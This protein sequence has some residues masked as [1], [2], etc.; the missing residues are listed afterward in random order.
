MQTYLDGLKNKAMFSNRRAQMLYSIHREGIHT[1]L[2]F[3]SHNH[4]HR[5]CFGM[6]TDWPDCIRSQQHWNLILWICYKVHIWIWDVTIFTFSNFSVC[7]NNRRRGFYDAF[8][9]VLTFKWK[10]LRS[11][12]RYCNCIWLCYL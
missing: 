9:F 4:S 12:H 8:V 2:V 6:F 1:L 3:C 7:F 10:Q 11:K 5:L